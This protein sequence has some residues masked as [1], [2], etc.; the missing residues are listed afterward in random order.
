[1]QLRVASLSVEINKKLKK[2]KEEQEWNPPSPFASKRV[3]ESR[4]IAAPLRF[5]VA[6]GAGQS[7]DL[8]WDG[9][10]LPSDLTF[11]SVVAFGEGLSPY[12]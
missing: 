8:S 10:A 5:V 12:V 9:W 6:F 3:R 1:M 2:N 7:L 11:A 4:T